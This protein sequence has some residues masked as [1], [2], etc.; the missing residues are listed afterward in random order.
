MVY[1]LGDVREQHF[2]RLTQRVWGQSCKDS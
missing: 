1:R 2:S